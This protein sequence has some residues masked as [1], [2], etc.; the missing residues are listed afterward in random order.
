MLQGQRDLL[1]VGAHD[2]VR[3]R[4]ARRRAAR[5]VLPMER[6]DGRRRPVRGRCGCSRRTRQRARS[7]ASASRSA[8]ASSGQAA[9]GEAAHP[10][11]PTCRPTTSRSLG[12]RRGAAD[13]ASSS[14]RCSSR[15]RSMA[16]IELAALRAVHEHPPAFLD[17]LTQSIG[18]VINTIEATMRTEDLLAAVAEP[19]R[20]AA[21]APAAS[22]SRRTK[23]SQRRRS[24][25]PSRTR[26]SSARTTRSSSRAARSKRRPRSS[27]SRRSTSREFLANMSHELRTPLNSTP[28]PRDSSSPTTSTATSPRSR[29][30]SRRTSTRRAPTCSR[31]STTSSTCRRSSR[32]RSPSSPRRSRSPTL[33]DTVHRTFRHVAEKK[34]LALHDRRRAEPARARS[35]PIRSACSRS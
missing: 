18:V 4:A 23:S 2:P 26:R 33:R 6:G 12:A 29:S 30:T 15:A 19:H 31:S 10:A 22:C 28:H 1:T 35:S 7:A 17:Q 14:C 13:A 8:R 32:A 20:R 27:R 16:V 34:G 5:R 9:L 21:D 11:R 24:S 3:A 25:S